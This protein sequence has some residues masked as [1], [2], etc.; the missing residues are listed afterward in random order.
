MNAEEAL[1]IVYFVREA[2][3]AQKFSEYTPDIWTELLADLTADDARAAC[4]VL[5][6][7]QA[8]IGPHDIRA[9]VK[10]IRAERVR[11]DF[12]EPEYDGAD[13]LGGLEAIR[14]H[15]RVIGDGLGVT[16]VP[17]LPKHDVEGLLN[18]TLARLPK[19]PREAN[20]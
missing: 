1:N 10:R 3:P 15:R 9:E 16:S 7:Q 8:F 13:V 4:V 14:Q 11:A 19:I 12:T 20:S 17:E 6:K 18:R 5:A 2:C